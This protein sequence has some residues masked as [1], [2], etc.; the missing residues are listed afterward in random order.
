MVQ[1]VGLWIDMDNMKA[2]CWHE[3]VM[4]VVMVDKTI[5]EKYERY[6]MTLVLAA[7]EAANL[8]KYRLRLALFGDRAEA[9]G[10]LTYA[11]DRLLGK[12]R[13]GFLRLFGKIAVN[14]KKERHRCLLCKRV[15]AGL[16]GKVC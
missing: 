3:G 12:K 4:P 10:D 5:R 2:R 8:L 7:E 13:K 1:V 9:R 16:V 6:V 11:S 14:P 15:M